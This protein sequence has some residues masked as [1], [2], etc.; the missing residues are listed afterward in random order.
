MPLLNFDDSIHYYQ[1]QEPDQATESYT[2]FSDECHYYQ[3]TSEEKLERASKRY[4]KFVSQVLNFRDD[5]DI[6]RFHIEF[7]RF[8]PD[9]SEIHKW[10]DTAV[11]RNV[12]ELVFRSY[13][14]GV[15][16]NSENGF[17]IPPSLCTCQSLTKM[18]LGLWGCWEY[19]DSRI[20]LP[21]RMSLP[22]LKSLR[23]SLHDMAFYDEQLTNMFF[24]SFPSLESSQSYESN[25]SRHYESNCEV[26][27]HTPSLSSFI[28]NGHVS[29]SF[30]L[31][32]L[33]SL[34]IADI[35]MDVKS[36]DRVSIYSTEICEE[37]KEMYAQ[38]TMGLL[39]GIHSVKVLKLHDSVLKALG[40]AP[41]ILDTQLPEYYNL[42]QLELNAYLTRDC[43][44]TIFAILKS[45]PRIESIFLWSQGNFLN[46]LLYPYCDEVKFNPENIGDY[47]D[48]GLSL[49]C[50]ICQVR[51]VEIKGLRGYVTELKFLEILLKHAT[52]L[53]KVV[54]S[55]YSIEQ[56][57]QRKKRM[58]KFSEMLLKFPTASKKILILLNL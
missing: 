23:L 46:P 43:L 33:S 22:G 8:R 34:A 11:S 9:V 20:T 12:Q 42:Q 31:E 7:H 21:D 2:D 56:G 39:R 54:I 37:K 55:S 53:E 6:Q 17:E 1:E 45:S 41:N 57:S 38:G 48:A 10:I 30:T 36:E 5:F 4:I 18:E 3:E 28:F 29:T 15:F 44:R 50:M 58:M 40:G 32:N 13:V 26:K 51:F 16:F 49:S 35:E 47:W 24:A 52:S 14:E 27:L 25:I 19:C